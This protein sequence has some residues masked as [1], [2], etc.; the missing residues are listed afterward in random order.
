MI[1]FISDTRPA[2]PSRVGEVTISS[3]VY[4]PTQKVKQNEETEESVPNKG[5]R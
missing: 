4:K 2:S 1:S 3:N 5:T